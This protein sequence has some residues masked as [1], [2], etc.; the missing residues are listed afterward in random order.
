MAFKIV[1][2]KTQTEEYEVLSQMASY[3]IVKEVET[4]KKYD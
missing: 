1:D 3:V 4:G 2:N